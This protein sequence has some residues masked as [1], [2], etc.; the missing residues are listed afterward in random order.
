[1]NPSTQPNGPSSHARPALLRRYIRWVLAAIVLSGMLYLGRDYL[2]E[3]HRIRDANLAGVLGIATV[4][5]LTLWLQGLTVKW[6]LDSFDRS[7][8]QKESFVLFVVASYANLFLPRSGVGATALYLKRSGKSNLIDYSSV[9]LMSSVL[10]VFTCSGVA[11]L[12]VGLDWLAQQTMPPIWLLCGLP[13][14]WL[15]SGLALTM[16]G[17]RFTHYR[18]PGS[19][20][21]QRLVNARTRMSASNSLWR[22]GLGHLVL[23]FLRALR[24]YCAFWALQI[25]ASFFAVLLTSL[26]GD[27]AF[28]FAVTPGALG[29]REAAIGVAAY[30]LGIP[31]SAAISVALLDRLVYSLTVVIA[32]NGLL[33]LGWKKL[34]EATS[35]AAC[36]EHPGTAS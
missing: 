32:A 36:S 33:A 12:S 27:L 19:S 10:F 25:E 35:V 17:V 23:V 11:C 6:G 8:S 24:L 7:I 2:G 9:V 4:H 16:R 31:V 18:G 29:F 21:I 14:L 30:R 15:G 20:L 34:P 5:L 22:M 28:I 26:L 13:A 1:M 3:W